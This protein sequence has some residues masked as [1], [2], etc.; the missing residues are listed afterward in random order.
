[1]KVKE[2][3]QTLLAFL[4]RELDLSGKA[5]KR[6]LERGACRL[7]GVIERF[8]STRVKKGDLVTFDPKKTELRAFSLPILYED[9]ELLI[10]NK[11]P[12]CLSD[13]KVFRS[14]LDRP[15]FLVHRL[16]KETSG[17]IILAKNQKIQQSLESLFRKREV[18]KIYL[19]LVKGR[20]RKQEGVIENHLAKK[21]VYQGQSV[22]GSRVKGFIA[23]THWKCLE[24][25]KNFSF[26]QCQ[27]KTGRTHQLRV[28]LSEMG[29]PILGDLLYGRHV[30][31]PSHVDR[32]FLH[33]YRIIFI[34]PKTGK[35]VQAT[36][37]I[38]KEFKRFL[39]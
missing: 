33:A 31:F 5:I 3:G 24:K 35:K 34:H 29:H 39:Q 14:F 10:C 9:S 12:G 16:D 25:G 4:Q 18:V 36:A 19:A 2:G 38:P 20:M 8:A 22:W 1:M 28:H 26:L 15:V 6:G 21:K 17:A 7:N 32:L 13:A 27:P 23:I 30:S 11:P 37:P